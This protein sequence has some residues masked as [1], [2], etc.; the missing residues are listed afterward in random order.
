MLSNCQKID[1]IF[2]S[3]DLSPVMSAMLQV[4]MIE[5][6]TNKMNIED[7][8]SEVKTVLDYMYAG[9]IN[10]NA[11]VDYKHLIDVAR[12]AQQ[13]TRFEAWETPPSNFI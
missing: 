4:D 2:S 9:Y 12:F 7:F 8:D 13:Y 6:A 5:K 11:P 1:G 3:T 10:A